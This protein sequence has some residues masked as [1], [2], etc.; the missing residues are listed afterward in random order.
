MEAFLR[1]CSGPTRNKT[2]NANNLILKTHDRDTMDRRANY[3][4][5]IAAARVVCTWQ[6]IKFLAENTSLFC[7]TIIR[8]YLVVEK[9][10]ISPEKIP[11]PMD[12]PERDTPLRA[13]VPPVT[14]QHTITTRYKR[15][16]NSLPSTIPIQSSVLTTQLP[17]ANLWAQ[18]NN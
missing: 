6:N 15:T 17:H 10:A 13:V 1:Y 16:T 7:R 18:G 9:G 8:K 5:S 4:R 3:R 11:L 14:I 12:P 2:P